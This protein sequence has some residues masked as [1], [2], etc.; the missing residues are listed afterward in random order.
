MKIDL[1]LTACNINDHYLSLYPYIVRVWKEKFGLDCHLI[2][3]ANQIPNNLKV[4]A[5]NI[6][7]FDPIPGINPVFVAQVIRILYLHQ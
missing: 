3:I 2:L 5:K 4:Y 7:L 1:V 6:T